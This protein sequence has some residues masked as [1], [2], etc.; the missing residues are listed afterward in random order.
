[1]RREKLD[2]VRTGKIC[3]KKDGGRQKEKIFDS[4]CLWQQKM[5]VQK[6]INGDCMTGD[7]LS[8]QVGK[9]LDD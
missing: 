4:L 3:G 9:A 8:M 7:G 6:L 1:M 5:S 2:H